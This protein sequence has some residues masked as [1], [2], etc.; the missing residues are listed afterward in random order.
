[1]R[2]IGDLAGAHSSTLPRETSLLTLPPVW[3][4]TSAKPG[5]GVDMLRDNSNDTFWQCVAGRAEREQSR[6]ARLKLPLRRSDGTQ[7]HLINIAFQRKV[8]LVVRGPAEL[9]AAGLTRVAGAGAV[10]GL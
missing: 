8:E 6:G 1:M 4:V 3:T 2:E 7:P 10:H 5:N 9:L